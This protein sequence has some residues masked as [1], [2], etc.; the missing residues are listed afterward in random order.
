ME[1]WRRQTRWVLSIL[2]RGGWRM[3]NNDFFVF[4][5]YLWDWLLQHTNL[6]LRSLQTITFLNFIPKILLPQK[7]SHSYRGLFSA[8]LGSRYPQKQMYFIMIERIK[9][10]F[11]RLSEKFMW[12][13]TILKTKSW[14]NGR[15]WWLP[16]RVF[17]FIVRLRCWSLLFLIFRKYFYWLRKILLN[18]MIQLTNIG[19]WRFRIVLLLLLF[20]LLLSNILFP[21]ISNH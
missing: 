7:S 2:R 3:L 5:C 18:T 21:F 11:I 15:K 13:K 9:T 19:F 4:Y 20:K 1:I 12:I 16:F 6:L 17:T 8:S 10:N 14:F